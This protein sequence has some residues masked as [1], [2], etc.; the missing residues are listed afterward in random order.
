VQARFQDGALGLAVGGEALEP[1]AE[2]RLDLGEAPFELLDG[3]LAFALKPLGEVVEALVKPLCAGVGDLGE[4]RAERRARFALEHHHGSVELTAEPPGGVL[5]G[6]FD[7][8]GE[9]LLGSLGEAL[10]GAGDGALELLDLSALRI[11]EA[12]LD[13]ADR[14]GFLA[15]DQ[16]EHLLLASPEPLSDLVEGAPALSRVRLEL[17]GSLRA[18]LL[19]HL[20]EL[21]AQPGERGPL[22][23]ALRGDPL[24]VV[25]AARLDLGDRGPLALREPRELGRQRLLQ[26]AK[27][28]RPLLE[29]PFDLTLDVGDGAHELVARMPLALVDRLPPLVGDPPLLLGQAR[30]RFGA[31]PG[32]HAFE[33]GRLLDPFSGDE[34]FQLRAGA[35]ELPV[36]GAGARDEPAHP[37]G[38]D[39]DEDAGRQPAGGECRFEVQLERERHPRCGCDHGEDGDDN[40]DRAGADTLERRADEGAHR[41]DDSDRECEPESGPEIHGGPVYACRVA[42]TD[43]L[44]RIA[45]AA[46]SF[47]EN[48]E[49]LVGVLAAEPQQGERAYVCSYSDGERRSWLVLD[50]DGHPV[51]SRKAVR[52]AVSIAGLCE[53]AAEAAGG[54]DLEELRSQLVTLRLTERPEGIEEA[55]EAALSLERAIGAPPV[56]ATPAHLDEVGAATLRLERALGN[57]MSSPFAEA[58]KAAGASIDALVREVEAGY[59]G[60]LS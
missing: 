14:L 58:M 32:E 51:A 18:G 52:D 7:R 27:V 30:Q 4:P 36:D 31:L 20:P 15:L 56:L 17:L 2:I 47:A 28:V 48:D 43:E 42:L 24:G 23:L 29:A 57:G 19:G 37:E 25:R 34:R 5:A 44:E 39:G 53:L 13:P 35:L 6:S 11:A 26:P 33:L 12:G 38:G 60:Q 50:A 3:L 45:P 10:R 46:A 8:L 40:R 41:D 49:Q 9:L 1:A 22:L 55:E 16:L 59:K 21:F 54:G